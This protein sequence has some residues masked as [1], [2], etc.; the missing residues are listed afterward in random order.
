MM[1]IK[2]FLEKNLHLTLCRQS[3]PI[4]A[5]FPLFPRYAYAFFSNNSYSVTNSKLEKLKLVFDNNENSLSDQGLIKRDEI[6][7]PTRI[8]KRLLRNQEKKQRTQSEAFKKELEATE[9]NNLEDFIS[10]RTKETWTTQ[11]F[12]TLLLYLCNFEDLSKSL[13]LKLKNIYDENH[14]SLKYLFPSPGLGNENFKLFADKRHKSTHLFL[15]HYLDMNP[16]FFTSLLTVKQEDE[17]L[18]LH[19]LLSAYFKNKGFEFFDIPTLFDILNYLLTIDGKADVQN[20]VILVFYELRSR[21][22]VNFTSSEIA[23]IIWCLGKFHSKLEISSL[24]NFLRGITTEMNARGNSK[25]RQLSEMNSSTFN[26][27]PLEA[28]QGF[29]ELTFK[30]DVGLGFFAEPIWTCDNGDNFTMLSTG[31]S[32]S[33]ISETNLR[34]LEKNKKAQI[35]ASETF[36][37][38]NAKVRLFG[39]L[40]L[41]TG[42]VCFQIEDF[43]KPITCFTSTSPT[44]SNSLG[45]ILGYPDICYLEIPILLKRQPF[46]FPKNLIQWKSVVILDEKHHFT[47]LLDTA[48]IYSI[49]DGKSA[50]KLL[51]NNDL[52]KLEHLGDLLKINV[53]FEDGSHMFVKFRVIPTSRS[54]L[55]IGYS[56]LVKIGYEFPSISGK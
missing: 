6:M 17:A 46:A 41:L 42:K 50:E 19:P 14:P 4:S 10:S 47:A 39:K 33:L 9:L 8:T 37:N 43:S 45:L 35:L 5:S 16:D 11:N 40:H 7:M 25:F 20:E 53:K 31:L 29:S 34:I 56:D 27:F 23:K 22:W 52:S 44:S 38:L 54:V 2:L 51:A 18:I 21:K 1:M 30:K 49:I 48:S 3:S 26:M 32:F 28:L 24:Q 55:T 36:S 12:S 13:I 15:F